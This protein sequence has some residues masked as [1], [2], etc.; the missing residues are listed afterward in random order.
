MHLHPIRQFIIGGG[1]VLGHF[2]L[3]GGS[4]VDATPADDRVGLVL[5][6]HSLVSVHRLGARLQLGS[7]LVGAEIRVLGAD[8]GRHTGDD[9]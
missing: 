1:H 7:D 6:A 4:W 3:D 5:L 9:R 8:E 2:R